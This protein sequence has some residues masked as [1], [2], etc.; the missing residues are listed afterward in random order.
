MSRRQLKDQEGSR[1]DA[2]E[3]GSIFW[4]REYKHDRVSLVEA[5]SVRM[6]E[7]IQET[8]GRQL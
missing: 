3:S 4:S 1:I 5:V 7:A 2:Q 6:L 8:G